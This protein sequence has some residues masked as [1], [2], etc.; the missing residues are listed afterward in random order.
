MWAGLY[1]RE[2]QGELRRLAAGCRAGLDL[3]AAKGDLSIWLLRRPEIEQVVAVEPDPGE[4]AQLQANLALNDL[5]ADRRLQLHAGF[6]GAGTTD[7]WRTLDQLAHG[8]PAPLFIKIDID[9]P[10]SEVLATGRV[11]LAGNCRLLIETHSPAAETGCISQLHAL[12]YQTRIIHPAWW[13]IFLPE[14]RPLPHNRWLTAWRQ[15]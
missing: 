13:R 6:A 7:Q 10:E 9:G 4:Q 5:A 14:R 15:P 3:G 1:E 8:L 2:R 11:T 12:G